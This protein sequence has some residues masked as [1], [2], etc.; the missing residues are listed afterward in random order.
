MKRLTGSKEY[1]VLRERRWNPIQ[2]FTLLLFAAALQGCQ[3]ETATSSADRAMAAQN[4]VGKATFE[5][6]CA[7]CHGKDALGGLAP[8]L[9]PFDRGSNGFKRTVRYGAGGMM[10]GFSAAEISDA[11]IVA[12]EGYLRKLSEPKQQA[13]GMVEWPYVGGDRNSS[14]YSPLENLTA[15]NVGEL[16]VAW[17]WRPE[18]AP[19]PE[20]GTIPGS[21]TA[22]PLMID[23]V[24]YVT[25]NYNRVA[26]LDAESGAVR[27]IYD[28]EAFKLGMPKLGG[29]FRH[30]GVAAWRD[31]DNGDRMNLFLASRYNLI[32]IDAQT[33]KPVAS[34]GEN[35][36]VDTSGDLSWEI[37]PAD[38]EMN[39]APA[40]Y[41]DLII[42]GSAIGDRLLYRNTPP[43]DVRA[44]HA[45]T[46]EMVW[47][48]SPIPQSPQEAGADTWENETWRDAGQIENWPG[49]TVDAEKGLVYVPTG[50]PGNLY[51]GGSRP[52]D[53]LFSGSLVALD[54]ATGE[55]QWHY[56][57]IH[58]G[59]WD[60]SMPT[61]PML[62]EL[63]VDGRSIDAVVQLSKQGFVY[64][65]D[66]VSGEPVW[67]IEE[68]EVPQSDVPGEQTSLTQ[69][70]PTRPPHLLP[71]QGMSSDDV[72]D[73]TPALEAEARKAM[74]QYR[75][76]PMFTP[77]S[78]EGTIARPGPA[79]VVSWGGGALDPESGILYVKASNSTRILRVQKYDPATSTNP[80]AKP[81]DA[82]WIDHEPTNTQATFADGIPLHKP[83][84]AYLVAMD[85][86]RG[87]IIWRVPFGIGSEALRT[88]P[89]LEDVSLPD[90]L[91][92]PGPPG[93]ILTKGG[94]IFIGGG[95]ETFWAF[96]KE[97]GEEVW[98]EPLP[99]RSSGNPI[100]YRTETG[101]QFVLIP[102]GSGTDQ[103]LIAY[104]I[105]NK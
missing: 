48:W 83:P 32:S 82:D 5:R 62:M 35:G 6:I 4:E 105:P 3:T 22:M 44:Y 56:Q 78:L 59:L 74:T 90:R 61:Q 40:V 80:F 79:G 100:T 8:A 94:L 87:E 91:G 97:T 89:S 96:D 99:R 77:P 86:N 68:R 49:V 18:E 27:W 84:Y 7:I 2:I 39:A 29:G 10:M 45:R 75:T 9:L 43:G 52:G 67:P 24:V 92:A 98:Q 70:F 65:F 66:R 1:P 26:A 46:G 53:N 19:M 55:R 33:G 47:R 41:G 42:V 11:E 63:E 51:Y 73:L 54:A 28:P 16:Q 64:V 31:S 50:N 23:G 102:T 30:R 58:H 15:E 14:R 93:S 60:Y 81:E 38:F 72:F 37:D 36:V 71:S 34:F 57:A 25:T 85:L 13:A 21:F 76:G 17:R 12:I 104:A 88:H 69:L 95:D 103:E 101:R 20:F